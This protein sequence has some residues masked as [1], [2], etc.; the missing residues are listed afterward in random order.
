MKN[1]YQQSI[2]A[3][4]LAGLSERTQLC[5]TRS[6]RQLADFYNLLPSKMTEQ[7]LQVYFLH[8]RNNNKWSAAALR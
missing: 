6:V 4:Q 7:Q 3:L 8:R 1:Y 2:K 5:Y